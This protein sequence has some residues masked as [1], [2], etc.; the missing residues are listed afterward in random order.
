MLPAGPLRVRVRIPP[1]RPRE[2]DAV[3]TT[4]GSQR[5]RLRLPLG[6]AVEGALLD[7]SSGAPLTSI[8]V[9]GTIVGA[10]AGPGGARVEATTDPA[11]RWKLGPLE[12]GRWK[13][14]IKLPGYL[15]LAREVE[16]RRPRVPGE[17]SVRDVRLELARGALVGGTVRD[18]RGQRVAGR[19]GPRAGRATAPGRSSRARPMTSASSGSATCR[20]ATSRSRATR[21]DARGRD[22][23]DAA[24]RRRGARALD[25][26]GV[27]QAAAE[28]GAS[29]RAQPRP[30]PRIRLMS[31]IIVGAECR[32]SS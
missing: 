7:G 27:N 20:P 3:A 8:T 25:R 14:A 28:L 15:P 10:G 21:G 30:R 31:M 6:G 13:L 16:S 4:G 1:I 32:S 18:A 22:P 12:P 11:G 2:L 19:Q 23:G 5:A 17:T 9:V 26:P 24:A 29:R